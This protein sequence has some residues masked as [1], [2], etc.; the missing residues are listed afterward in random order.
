MKAL[1]PEQRR[2]LT[3]A[4][5]GRLRKNEAGRYV[6]EG[7]ARP[8][9]RTRERLLRRYLIYRTV[10]GTVKL[11]HRGRELLGAS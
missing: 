5:N 3:A 9:R 6:I 4:A 11:T 7:D 2:I 1:S 10:D 8:E